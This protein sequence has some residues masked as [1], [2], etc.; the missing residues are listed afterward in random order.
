M[1]QGSLEVRTSLTVRGVFFVFSA[2]SL[3][4]PA[5]QGFLGYGIDE[6]R[7]EAQPGEDVDRREELAKGGGRCEVAYAHGRQ[8]GDAEVESVHCAPTLNRPVEKGPTQ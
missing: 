3:P 5:T 1:E 2:T 4:S 7:D 8:R 6:P